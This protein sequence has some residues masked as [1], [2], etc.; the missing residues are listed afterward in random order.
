M[1]NISFVISDFGFFYSH[2]FDLAKTLVRNYGYTINIVTSLTKASRSNIKECNDAKIQLTHFP[3]RLETEGFFKYLRSFFLL[4]KSLRT[5][6]IIF[7]TLEMSF[8]GSFIGTFIKGYRSIFLISGLGHHFCSQ[9]LKI[10]LLRIIQ[11]IVFRAFERFNGNGCFIFQNKDDL[12]LFKNKIKLIGSENF[13]IKGNG[14]DA[15]KY[16]FRSRDFDDVCFCYAGRPTLSKGIHHLI[17]SFSLLKA[18]NPDLRISLKLMLLSKES[19]DFVDVQE[20]INE[21]NSNY[22]D[23]LY[24]LDQKELLKELHKCQIF[25][26]PSK[27]EG[28]PK[29][30]LEAASTGLPIIAANTPG[31][32]EVVEQ[33]VNGWLLE[34]ITQECLKKTMEESLIDKKLLY[35]MSN[36]SR[37][38]IIKY[39][40]LSLI[41]REYHSIFSK[42]DR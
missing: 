10:K 29:A 36:N 35:D 17:S 4:I 22:V 40:E 26:I 9:N 34:N 25:V 14:I 18:C 2:R 30:A 31:T 1:K 16:F 32:K 39:F 42:N 21:D 12:L 11:G 20:L 41:A 38:H 28:I 8:L 23:I 3:N 24:D 15:K 5:D 27:R 33:G 13:I 7:V 37:K 6:Q 19:D